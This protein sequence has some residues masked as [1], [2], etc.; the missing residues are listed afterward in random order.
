MDLKSL[1]VGIVILS[2]NDPQNTYELI[3]SIFQSDYQN[4]DVIVVDNNSK[5][6]NFD[7]F[8]SN[9]KKK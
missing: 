1:K 8:L 6:E 7:K 2:W 5:S 3:E 9:L 4:F